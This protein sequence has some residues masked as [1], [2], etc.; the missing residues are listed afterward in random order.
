MPSAAQGRIEMHSRSIGSY[1]CRPINTKGE[2]MHR[3]KFD[4]VRF[5]ADA[6]DSPRMQKKGRETIRS[7]F[8]LTSRTEFPDNAQIIKANMTSHRAAKNLFGNNR[9]KQMHGMNNNSAYAR[10]LNAAY[11]N[12]RAYT[13][14]PCTKPP[15][16][17][18]A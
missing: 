16:D 10:H 17:I 3:Y 1:A 11:L 15:S 14:T 8:L 7:G 5:L 9:A 13:S 4:T 18:D 2:P 6:P 12:R